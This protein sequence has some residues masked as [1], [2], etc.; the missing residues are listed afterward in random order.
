MVWREE[1]TAGDIAASFAMTRPS[2]SQHLAVLLES[3]LVTVRRADTRRFY[4][5]NRQAVERLRGELATLW[6]NGLDELKAHAY[7]SERG[8]KSR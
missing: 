8:K 1:R 7:A 6:D 4:R 5:A 2:V 3:D